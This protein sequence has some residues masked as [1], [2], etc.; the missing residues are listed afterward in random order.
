MSVSAIR[1]NAA[2]SISDDP[3][4]YRFRIAYCLIGLATITC[5]II[6]LWESLHPTDVNKNWCNQDSTD[7]A[8]GIGWQLS[9]ALTFTIC[10]VVLLGVFEMVKGDWSLLGTYTIILVFLTILQFIFC[11][12]FSVV[13]D[14]N[15]FA[16]GITPYLLFV[17]ML[18]LL[19]V[20]VSVS[21]RLSIV[22]LG[23]D[24]GDERDYAPLAPERKRYAQ[25]EVNKNAFRSFWSAPVHEIGGRV[26]VPSGSDA[27]VSS[28]DVTAP[29]NAPTAPV[30][31]PA[32]P[33]STV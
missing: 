1:R 2:D 5:A 8:F 19:V 18:F 14:F 21:R 27:A 22:I 20:L 12:Y 17:L 23:G 28:S 4:V 15:C 9:C 30:V 11:I 32:A 31:A 26:E 24:G 16:V 6:T 7:V 13:D 33:I 10:L 29:L 3:V 25:V